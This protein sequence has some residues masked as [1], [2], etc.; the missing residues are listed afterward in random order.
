VLLT[1]AVSSAALLLALGAARA[2]AAGERREAFFWFGMTA[3]AFVMASGTLPF[4]WE[5]PFLAQVQF[6]SRM[7]PIAEFAA[8]TALAIGRPRLREP[9]VFLGA[10][11]AIGALA[12]TAGAV[13]HA[14]EKRRTIGAEEIAK[15]RSD[16]RDAPEYLPAGFPIAASAEG[17]PESALIRLPGVAHMALEASRDGGAR[18]TVESAEPGIVVLR[19]FHFP[20]W[21]V[22]DEAG[23]RV[24]SGPSPD[25]LL[26]WRAEAG[27]SVFLVSRGAAPGE[28]LGLGVSAAALL[29]LA[30]ASLLLF[31]RRPRRR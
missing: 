3:I 17:V 7:L 31:R 4:L 21:R 6:P 2:A 22:T 19:R 28:R 16:W 20:H 9:L 5:L 23:R 27:R 13:A 29:A 18:V 26:S 15:I 10:L 24:P 25:R 11:P 8:V 30:L 1:M 12:T 14:A